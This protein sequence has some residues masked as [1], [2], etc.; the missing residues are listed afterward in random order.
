MALKQTGCNNPVI[1]LDEID[2]LSTYGGGGGGNMGDPAGALL[3]ILDPEQNTHF[4]DH[5]LGVP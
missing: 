4:N 1:L 2:K 5:Y 3:E